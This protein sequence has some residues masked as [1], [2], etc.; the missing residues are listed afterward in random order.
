MR[1]RYKSLIVF[2]ILLLAVFGL[3]TSAAELK[4]ERYLVL[5]IDAAT[6]ADRGWAEVSVVTVYPSSKTIVMDALDNTRFYAIGGGKIAK[7]GEIYAIGGEQMVM[8]VLNSNYF[9]G[10]SKYGKTTYRGLSEI[11][12]IFGAA[13]DTGAMISASMSNNTGGMRAEQVKMID[14]VSNGVKKLTLSKI[15]DLVVAAFKHIVSNVNVEDAYNIAVSM[16]DGTF[17]P[18][19]GKNLSVNL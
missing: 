1:L 6:P 10:I 14:T 19:D 2:V 4:T 5:V 13:L 16:I 17:I 3:S 11:A 9:L 7:L 15:H 8:S 18:Y 12:G